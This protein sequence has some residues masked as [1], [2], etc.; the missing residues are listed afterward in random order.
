MMRRSRGLCQLLPSDVAGLVD[1][2]IGS[3]ACYLADD[4]L[5]ELAA[6]RLSALLSDRQN[7]ATGALGSVRV[8]LTWRSWASAGTA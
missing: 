7:S 4:V 8:P 1:S 5:D 3:Q 6:C 2:T